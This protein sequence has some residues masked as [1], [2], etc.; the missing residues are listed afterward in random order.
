MP[1]RKADIRD[2]VSRAEGLLRERGVY[3]MPNNEP[4]LATAV[5]EGLRRM[6]PNADLSLEKPRFGGE[7]TFHSKDHLGFKKGPA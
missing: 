2:Y 5:Y 1:P 7:A 6:Y 3:H 4:V